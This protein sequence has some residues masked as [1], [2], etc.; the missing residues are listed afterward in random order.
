MRDNGG[1]VHIDLD[2]K[3]QLSAKDVIVLYESISK[4]MMDMKIVCICSME[5]KVLEKH[6]SL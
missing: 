6:W 1:K 3:K 5:I 2:T 4:L